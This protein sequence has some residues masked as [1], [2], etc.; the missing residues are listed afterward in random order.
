MA[1]AKKLEIRY[2]IPAQSELAKALTQG[3]RYP[4]YVGGIGS[5]K[6]YLGCTLGF[7]YGIKHPKS[8][9]MIV[10]PSYKMLKRIVLPT[11]MEDT[12]LDALVA[13]HNKADG[14]LKLLSGSTVF[15]ASCDNPD[16]LRGPNLAW[17]YLDEAALASDEA[18]KIL[19]GRLRQ[20]G[21]KPW[22]LAGTTPKGKN[23]VWERWENDPKPGYQL[24][25]ARTAD[26]PHLEAQFVE[27]LKESYSGVFA[28][29][30]LEGLFERPEGLVYEEFDRAVHVRDDIQA[31]QFIAGVDWGYTNPSVILVIGVTGD[32]E[33]YVIDELYQ[34]KLTVDELIGQARDIE[35]PIQ[36]FLCDPSEPAY[37]E[38][39][40][41]AGLAAAPG[42]NDVLPGI[43]EVKRRLAVKPNGRPSLFI[44]PRC[45]NLIAE[46]ESYCWQDGKERPEK[47]NDH[48]MDALRYALM[49]RPSQAPSI[50]IY[51]DPVSISPF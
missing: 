28:R 19:I 43:N 29:Q 24:F 49:R 31:T 2:D 18:W 34:R 3:L 44:H 17:F 45:V 47:Q 23:W 10:A 11:I 5:G 9:G 27:D 46:L 40:R 15:L 22:C 20:P 26:N 7:A 8:R 6:T 39:F 4:A 33:A 13:E 41:R 35:Y 1:D 16:S 48:A 12:G 36:A 42:V 38:Q 21:F 50:A 14:I 32:D 51:H 37:I 30:E 25:R